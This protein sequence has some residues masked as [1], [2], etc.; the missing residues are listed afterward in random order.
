MTNANLNSIFD[1]VADEAGV[2]ILV[3][4]DRLLPGSILYLKAWKH[5]EAPKGRKTSKRRKLTS[6]EY[7]VMECNDGGARV[8]STRQMMSEMLQQVNSEVNELKEVV[9]MRIEK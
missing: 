7:D 4:C 1:E 3:I 2:E 6:T 5:M 8:S 9:S